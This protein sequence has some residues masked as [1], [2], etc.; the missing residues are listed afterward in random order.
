MTQSVSRRRLWRLLAVAALA[1]ALDPRL[2]RVQAQLPVAEPARQVTLF[3]VIAVPGSSAIDPKLAGIEPQLRQTPTRPWVQAARRT[4]QTA[5]CGGI[6]PLRPGQWLDR[7]DRAGAAARPE[8]QG[9]APLQAVAERCRSVR[10]AG[11]DTPEPA[12][13]LRPDDRQR[14]AAADRRR[15]AVKP[16]GQ[17]PDSSSPLLPGAQAEGRDPTSLRLAERV[18]GRRSAANR[19]IIPEDEL[20]AAAPKDSDRDRSSVLGVS[21]RLSGHVGR[22]WPGPIGRRSVPGRDP[23]DGTSS[24]RPW[25]SRFSNRCLLNRHDR[26]AV[27]NDSVRWAGRRGSRDASGSRVPTACIVGRGR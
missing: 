27:C 3:A 2:P 11:R 14:Q 16:C 24:S 22:P 23:G 17:E 15:G 13:L 6:G 10:Y 21:L 1:V 4:Q 7:L 20:A 9:R 8:R 19:D 12:L 26:V 5:S 18:L 25:L